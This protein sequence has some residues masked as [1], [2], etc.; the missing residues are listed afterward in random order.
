LIG[1]SGPEA[2]IPLS[3]GGY[4]PFV[5][6]KLMIEQMFAGSGSGS[7]S[8]LA[9]LAGMNVGGGGGM[10]SVGTM[11]KSLTK[12]GGHRALARHLGLDKGTLGLPL[13]S[14]AAVGSNAYLKEQRA[15]LAEEFIKNPELRL[16]A[17]ALTSL[18]NPGA[19]PAVMESL[20]NRMIYSNRTMASGMSGGPKSFYGPARHPGMVESRMEQIRRNPAMF[21][22]LDTL[23]NT[24]FGGSNVVKGYTDQGSAGDPN[25]MR[26]A[27]E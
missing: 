18:E 3:G 27:L 16:R 20:M 7:R 24:A 14:S 19:G 22:K 23:M 26:V 5:A 10:G 12:G 21:A 25:Y 13:P 2:V 6:L 15:R 17:A 4:D 8:K 11:P 9:A 1:E